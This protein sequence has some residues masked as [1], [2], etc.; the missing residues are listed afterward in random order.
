MKSG[1]WLAYL[2]FLGLPAL[3]IGVVDFGFYYASVGTDWSPLLTVSLGVVA[4]TIF[5]VGMIA[6]SGKDMADFAVTSLIVIVLTVILMPVFLRARQNTQRRV[7]KAAIRKALRE[8]GAIYPQPMRKG[9][10]S[11]D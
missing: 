5:V 8:H 1:N 11:L 3:A 9:T 2:C 10:Q 6:A 7:N 4:G